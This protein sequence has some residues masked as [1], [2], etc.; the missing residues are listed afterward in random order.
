M[1]LHFTV[2]IK[3]GQDTEYQF[4]TNTVALCR[5]KGKYIIVINSKLFYVSSMDIWRLRVTS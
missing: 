4:K 3:L 2:L 1:K 5:L